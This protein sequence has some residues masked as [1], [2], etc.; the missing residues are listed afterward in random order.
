MF[1]NI[2]A[3]ILHDWEVAGET[4]SENIGP[5]DRCAIIAIISG[6]TKKLQD[7]TRAV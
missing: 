2:I 7:Y 6:M 5:F 4:I 3:K 1:N